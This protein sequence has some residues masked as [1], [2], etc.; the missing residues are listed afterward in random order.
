MLLCFSFSV[1]AN[2]VGVS[3]EAAASSDVSIRLTERPCCSRASNP[4]KDRLADVL[5]F[6]E[7]LALANEQEHASLLTKARQEYRLDPSAM[8][9]LR[10]ALIL[11]ESEATGMTTDGGRRLLTAL[12]DDSRLELSVRAFVRLRLARLNERLLLSAKLETSGRGNAALGEQLVALKVR[13]ALA[14]REIQQLAAELAE[15]QAKLEALTVIEESIEN[16]HNDD[17]LPP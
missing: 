7:R 1:M 12:Q 5:N 4:R 2:W 11:S 17:G 13:Q 8:N 15:A 10:F 3:S 14:Q 16:V 9:R 6:A